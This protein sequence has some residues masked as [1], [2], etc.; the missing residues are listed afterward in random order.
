MQKRSIKS[1]GY[2]KTKN[3]GAIHSGSNFHCLIFY[4]IIEDQGFIKQN[5]SGWPKDYSYILYQMMTGDGRKS[6]VHVHVDRETPVHVHLKKKKKGKPGVPT[7]VE[8]KR[9]LIQLSL[10]V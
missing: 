5:K 6:P 4:L 9:V 2:V 10:L 1:K 8:V 3:S 7:A